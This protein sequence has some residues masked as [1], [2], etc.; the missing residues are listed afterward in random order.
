MIRHLIRLLSR[1][2]PRRSLLQNYG[3]RTAHWLRLRAAAD[4]VN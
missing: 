4:G 2:R 3:N 1:F